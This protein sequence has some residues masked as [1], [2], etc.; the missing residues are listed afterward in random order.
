MLEEVK[1][2]LDSGKIAFIIGIFDLLG[3]FAVLISSIFPPADPQNFEM[4]S[5]LFNSFSV[6][7]GFVCVIG[8]LFGIIGIVSKKKKKVLAKIGLVLNIVVLLVIY[9]GWLGSILIL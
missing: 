3:L 2:T 9:I 8:I 5:F 6:F 1:T 4:V 7:I